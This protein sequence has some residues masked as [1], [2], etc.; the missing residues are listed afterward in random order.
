M[1][2]FLEI[3]LMGFW[4]NLHATWQSGCISNE[5]WSSHIF[6]SLTYTSMLAATI[7][8]S[9]SRCSIS[10]KHW[11]HLKI[12]W[13][14]VFV[15]HFSLTVLNVHVVF[16]WIRI[17]ISCISWFENGLVLMF[18]KCWTRFWHP[19]YM[20]L[21]NPAAFTMLESIFISSCPS[22][23][24]LRFQSGGGSNACH[25]SSSMNMILVY[26]HDEHIKVNIKLALL[27][28]ATHETSMSTK[29]KRLPPAI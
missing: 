26:Q 24:T 3:A 21:K 9:C 13:N 1:F 4:G 6:S 20:F 10:L 19:L 15:G 17:F 14:A 25:S 29:A 16:C 27:A 22:C 28:L 12:W 7:P 11:I 8:V 2:F 23:L 5:L 18:T